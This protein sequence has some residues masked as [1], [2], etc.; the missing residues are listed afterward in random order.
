MRVAT[1]GSCAAALLLTLATVSCGSPSGAGS[2]SPGATTASGSS[3][4]TAASRATTTPSAANALEAFFAAADQQD[5]QLRSAADLINNGVS[6]SRITLSMSTKTAVAAIDPAIVAR[7]IP[8]GLDPQLQRAVLVVYS[9]LDSRRQAM[10][11]VADLAHEP[12]TSVLARNG[13]AVGG[14]ID[15]MRCLVNGAPAAARYTVDVASARA[16]AQRIPAAASASPQSRAAADLALRIALINGHNIGCASCGGFVA[17]GL[18]PVTWQPSTVAG[19][20]WDGTIGGSDSTP[21]AGIRFQA[22]YLPG[23]GWQVRLNAC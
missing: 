15:L 4:A 8:A 23:K 6:A 3:S 7:T 12:G 18:E 1:V 21:A 20:H 14:G 11:R 22:T 9:E 13:T 5:A 17:A 2:S 16:L 19:I 10:R